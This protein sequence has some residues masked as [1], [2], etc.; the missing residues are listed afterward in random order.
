MNFAYPIQAILMYF[1]MLF[2]PDDV[3]RI[4]LEIP[5]PSK[6]IEMVRNGNTWSA[7]GNAFG[8][9]GDSLL[10]F[11][12]NGKESLKLSD[13]VALPKNHDW[14]KNP[15]FTLGGGTVLGKTATGFILRRNSADSEG[16]GTYK[17][18]YHK[19]Q[20]Q[21]GA[22]TVNVLGKVAN[23]GVHRLPAN[24]TVHD[25]LAA[26]AGQGFGADMK[27]VSIIRGPAGSVPEVTTVDLTKTAASAPG[28]QAGDTIHVPELRDFSWKAITTSVEQWL[29]K[30][31]AG[32]YAQ[33]WSDGSVFFRESI[34]ADDWTETM[35]K[36][37]KPLG[38]VKE[39]IKI[40][41]ENI[42]SLPGAPDGEYVVMKWRSSFEMKGEAIETVTFREEADG[43]WKAAGYFIR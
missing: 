18:V 9:E 16:N 15:E 23:Q 12:A 32:D 8:I 31:D 29:A 22:M 4:T 19:R 40:A 20:S 14:N 10:V 24:S 5:D 6:R 37:R 21:A 39:R 36:A 3:D 42:H 35:T 34:T 38:E 7:E 28:I 13:F 30:V 43:T 17:I 26:A 2:A 27:R 25:A 1:A 11:G 41:Q 33:S